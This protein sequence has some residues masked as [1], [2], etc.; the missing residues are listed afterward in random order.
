MR[1]SRRDFIANI[2]KLGIG[3]GLTLTAFDILSLFNNAYA[4]NPMALKEVANENYDSLPGKKTKCYICPLNCILE[5][6]QTCF[7]RTRKNHAGKLFSHAYN[8]P[9]VLLVDPVEKT[10]LNHFL[11]GS[12]ALSIAVGGCN[13]RCL[14][15]QNW[16]QS[17]AKPEELKT[18][19][20]TSKDAV[21][22]AKKKDCKVIAYTYTEPASFYEYIM[23][24][25]A[26]AK[27]YK[28]KNVAATAAY[29]NPKPMKDL[30]KV[31]DGF[32]VALKGFDEKYYEKVLGS[33]LKPVLKALEVVKESGKWLEI[34]TLIVPTYNDDLTKIKEMCVWIKQNLGTKVP[35]HFARFVPEYKLKDLP[36]TPLQ[37]L[38]KCRDIAL[39]TGLEYV[40]LSNVAPHE[41]NDT[42]CP[43]CKG[44][45]VKRLG[46]KILEN[47]LDNGAC[48]KCGTKLPGVWN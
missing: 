24:I 5:D 34:T 30:C 35:Y 46:F 17:Q 21:E 10:P 3:A 48:K 12:S 9:C 36:R 18:F 19:E 32:A 42:F 38:E 28:I 4:A 14:Y 16:Q 26:L 27:E 43:K 20:L 31:I 23:E 8:N 44:K 1:Q 37:T 33:K 47:S 7:C 6:G 45:V 2:G 40:Y 11:P 13:L 41:G 25:A 29:I 15:C 22:G 39:E